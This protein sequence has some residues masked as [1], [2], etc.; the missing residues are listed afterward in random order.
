MIKRVSN[1]EP[2]IVA[3]GQSEKVLEQ[4]AQVL[5]D[6]GIP[7]DVQE[8]VGGDPGRPDWRWAVRVRMG[9]VDQARRALAQGSKTQTSHEPRPGPLFETPG[10]DAL[11]VLLMLVFFGL[12][13]ALWFR[14]CLT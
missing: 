3:R 1:S 7:F 14:G 5:Q 10:R 13:A 2:V 4:V 9:E 6:A 11:R 8:E 12:A